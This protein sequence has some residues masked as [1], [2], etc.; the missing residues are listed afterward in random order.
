MGETHHE[1]AVG[2]TNTYNE[3]MTEIMA[4]VN[5][6]HGV[7]VSMSHS[8]TI[9]PNSGKL[10]QSTIVLW[11]EPVIAPVTGNATTAVP[12]QETLSAPRQSPSKE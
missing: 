4:R 6:A 12:L 1:Q 11:K 10:Y 8:L 9:G 2:Q 7:I 3:Q 5:A